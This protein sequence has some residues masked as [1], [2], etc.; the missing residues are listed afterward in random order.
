MDTYILLVYM[1][2]YQNQETKK[3]KQICYKHLY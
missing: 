2:N 1:E 3:Q